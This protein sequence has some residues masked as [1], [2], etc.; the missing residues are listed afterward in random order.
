MVHEEEEEEA[1]EE[2]EL[3]GKAIVTIRDAQMDNAIN[4]ND[5]VSNSNNNNND[6]NTRFTKFTTI[7]QNNDWQRKRHYPD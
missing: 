5:N 4:N 6:E 3:A 7:E 2:V 1:E